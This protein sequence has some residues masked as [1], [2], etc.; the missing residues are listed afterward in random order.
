MP[1]KFATS[2]QDYANFASGRVFY[3]LPGYPAFPIRPLSEIFQRALAHLPSSEQLTLYDPCCGAAYHLAVLG[4][5]HGQHLQTIIASDIDNTAVTTAARN[6]A[7]LTT[8]GLQNRISAIE[9]MLSDYGKQSHREAL[10]SAHQLQQILI[11]Y[12]PIETAIFTADAFDTA[13]MQAGLNSRIPDL[14]FADVPYG[15]HSVWHNTRPHIP[16]L[17]QLL[18]ALAPLT[19]AHTMVTIA[20]DKGQKIA[21][22][23]YQR[24]EKFN[25]GKRQIALLRKNA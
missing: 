9:Q 13:A 5:L 3:N 18:T 14:I 4:Y 21:H 25:I 8:A 10:A 2:Q 16:P 6:L 12:P 17:Q 22:E 20:A 11:R 1:Y 15:Q 23:H 19:A 24:L 7:L